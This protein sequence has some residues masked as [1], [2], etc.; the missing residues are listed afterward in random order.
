MATAG[1]PAQPGQANPAIHIGGPY[2]A[3]VKPEVLA[4]S[5]VYVT[6]PQK[7]PK[8]RNLPAS[9]PLIGMNLRHLRALFS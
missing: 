4:R 1:S 2:P 8:P 9:S 7:T 6:N 3:L 5:I